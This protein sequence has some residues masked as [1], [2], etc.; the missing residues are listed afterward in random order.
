MSFTPSL[1]K[2]IRDARQTAVG[3]EGLVSDVGGHIQACRL[4]GTCDR[5]N[6][7]PQ[8]KNFNNSAYKKWENEI[9]RALKEG[10]MVDAVS[11]KFSR[12]NIASPRPDSL[13]IDYLIDGKKFRKSFR[14]EAGK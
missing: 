2:G 3:K 10:S 9:K 1:Q 12:S 14:N 4:G 5:Y 13:F 11:I 6:L 7:F 8:D